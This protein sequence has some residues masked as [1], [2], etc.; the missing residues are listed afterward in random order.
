M[1]LYTAIPTPVAD[2]INT[3]KTS[4]LSHWTALVSALAMVVAC[5][6]SSGPEADRYGVKSRDG[7][8]RMSESTAE[9]LPSSRSSSWTLSSCSLSIFSLLDDVGCFFSPTAVFFLLR[10]ESTFMVLVWCCV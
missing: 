2:K 5:P 1:Y 7:P 10:R 3:N 9:I 4:S 8:S 6:S